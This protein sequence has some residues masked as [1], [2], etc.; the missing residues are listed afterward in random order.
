M[1]DVNTKKRQVVLATAHTPQGTSDPPPHTIV[2]PRQDAQ[3][4]SSSTRGPLARRW[5]REQGLKCRSP[6]PPQSPLPTPCPHL[7]RHHVVFSGSVTRPRVA[8]HERSC[9]LPHACQASPLQRS[10]FSVPSDPAPE[11]LLFEEHHLILG[12]L[13]HPIQP[14]AGL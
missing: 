8:G 1:A 7:C 12:W 13:L 9:P 3:A 11:K 6:A 5:Q 10:P 14:R 2:S 4:P